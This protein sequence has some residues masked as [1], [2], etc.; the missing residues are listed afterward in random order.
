MAAA[1]MRRPEIDS[2]LYISTLTKYVARQLNRAAT[3]LA[4]AIDA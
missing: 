4:A 1:A 3:T 2:A